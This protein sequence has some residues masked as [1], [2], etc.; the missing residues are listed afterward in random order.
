MNLLNL[1]NLRSISPNAFLLGLNNIQFRS[2]KSITTSKS[3]SVAIAGTNRCELQTKE[4]ESTQELVDAMNLIKN[5]N[6]LDSSMNRI[7]L[8]SKIDAKHES[9]NTRQRDSYFEQISDILLKWMNY[10]NKR[11][12]LHFTIKTDTLDDTDFKYGEQFAICLCNEIDNINVLKS[13]ENEQFTGPYYGGKRLHFCKNIVI[14]D[15]IRM[16]IHMQDVLDNITNGD[17]GL[18]LETNINFSIEMIANS[19]SV[20]NLNHEL[21]SCH[22]YPGWNF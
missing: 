7:C 2:L 15:R 13:L 19:L 14:N 11:V 4:F 12:E 16:G 3:P 22:C 1:T 6:T 21:I 17:D 18:Q 20:E 9:I 10:P 8:S 5:N